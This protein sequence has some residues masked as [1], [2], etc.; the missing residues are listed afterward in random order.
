MRCDFSLNLLK[1]LYLGLC[2]SRHDFQDLDGP[3]FGT[4]LVGKSVHP[5]LVSNIGE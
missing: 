3:K 5:R 1:G 2:L 4:N